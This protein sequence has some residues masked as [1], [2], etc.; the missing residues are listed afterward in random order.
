MC[1]RAA[2]EFHHFQSFPSVL[3]TTVTAASGYFWIGLRYIRSLCFACPFFVLC[4]NEPKLSR[5]GTIHSKELG[6][7]SGTDSNILKCMW[8]QAEKKKMMSSTSSCT[9]HRKMA[10][11][12]GVKDHRKISITLCSM[13]KYNMRKINSIN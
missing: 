8:K 4:K 10:G 12:K 3:G 6:R 2:Q 7:K 13:Q 1:Y 11:Y 9:G 5:P